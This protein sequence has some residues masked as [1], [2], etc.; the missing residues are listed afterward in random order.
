MRKRPVQ[1]RD[2]LRGRGLL[3]RWRGQNELARQ[4]TILRV[5]KRAVQ[6]Q[7]LGGMH[8]SGPSG[9]KFGAM[10]RAFKGIMPREE[11]LRLRLAAQ[12]QQR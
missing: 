2:S 5:A 8:E 3:R 7:V 6:G 4:E 10:R 9:G 1:Q 11:A 12:R